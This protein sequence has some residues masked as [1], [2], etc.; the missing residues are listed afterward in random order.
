VVRS[1]ETRVGQGV[2]LGDRVR[3]AQLSDELGLQP[4]RQIRQRIAGVV[5]K[6]RRVWVFW[7]MNMMPTGV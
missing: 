7:R 2:V 6:N 1:A 3:S 5:R 4:V